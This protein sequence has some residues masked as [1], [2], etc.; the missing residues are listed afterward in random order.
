MEFRVNDE[1]LDLGLEAGGATVGDMLARADE[2]LERA[3]AIIVGIRV[4]GREIDADSFASVRDLPAAGC[5]RIDI[6]AEGASGVRAKA[7]S[8]LLD[9]LEATVDALAAAEGT[10]WKALAHGTGELAEAFGGL[11]PADELG[12]V[13]GFAELT[14][15]AAAEAAADAA[16]RAGGGSAVAQPAIATRAEL[17]ARSGQLKAIFGERLDELRDPRAEMRKA[18]SLYASHAEELRE[19]PVYLQTGREDRAMKAVL[20]FIEIFNKVIRIMPLLA[21]EG[22]SVD[23]IRIEGQELP[24]FYSSFNEVLR[25]LSGALEDKDSVLIGD[26]AEYEV[27]PRMSEFFGAI[28]E[29]LPK[30]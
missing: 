19:L 2:L 9:L 4:D 27:A 24:L 30:T 14:A 13:R 10:D 6:A 22:L 28:E 3:G 23:G 15:R 26:L 8:T 18:A 12:Y 5:A 11:F 21:A 29:A 25:K 20:L 1:A 17:S 16:A 7:I